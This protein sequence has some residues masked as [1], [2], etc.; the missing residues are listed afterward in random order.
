MS[1]RSSEREFNSLEEDSVVQEIVSPSPRGSTRESSRAEKSKDRRREKRREL[2]K[3][4]DKDKKYTGRTKGYE[5]E[6]DMSSRRMSSGSDASN[7]S[8]IHGQHF[9]ITSNLGG[10]NEPNSRASSIGGRGDS[11]SY[12]GEVLSRGSAKGAP[13]PHIKHEK[14]DNQVIHVR[15]KRKKQQQQQ[16]QHISSR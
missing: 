15:N 2:R 7:A 10:H 6:S 16:M 14:A 8:D 11:G 9:N 4:K 3:R 13:S 5:D 1:D 12:G